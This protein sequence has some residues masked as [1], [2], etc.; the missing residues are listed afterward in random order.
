MGRQ[1]VLLSHGRN[2]VEAYEAEIGPRQID[3][4]QELWNVQPVQTSI[5]SDNDRVAKVHSCCA[6]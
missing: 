1:R 4:M 5:A 6:L 3:T 2:L